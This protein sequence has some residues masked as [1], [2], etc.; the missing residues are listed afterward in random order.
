MTTLRANSLFPPRV[1]RQGL[2]NASEL[3][4]K[5]GTGDVALSQLVDETVIDELQREGF[6]ESLKKK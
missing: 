5:D 2:R 1:N 3:V 6:F 4:S